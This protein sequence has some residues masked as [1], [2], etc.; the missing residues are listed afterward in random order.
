MVIQLPKRRS[1]S[2]L[3][4][5]LVTASVVA[6]YFHWQVERLAQQ[7]SD[8]NYSWMPA[9]PNTLRLL[10][11]GYDRLIADFVWLAFIN[12]VGDSNARL[13][14][15]YCHA[16]RYLDVVTALDPSFIQPF[17]FCAFII[18]S[19]QQRPSR[20]AQLIK[21]GFDANPSTWLLPY[22]A[23]ANDYLNAH[24][25]LGAAKWYRIAS[26]LPGA[27]SWLSRQS[28]ILASKIPSTIKEIAVW[29]AIYESE[30]SPMVRI[31]AKQRLIALWT[32][33]YLSSAK[34]L[35]KEKALKELSGFAR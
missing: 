19:D 12:Y 5:C 21:R 8:P 4:Y 22:I 13:K 27:P 24:D 34:G 18:G 35:I 29:R 26:T 31:Q 14:D 9:K 20:A 17:W 16:D 1:S 33:V 28:Q 32:K 10:G 25:E 7:V 15:K 6:L 3:V 2:V 11:L 30:P 23:G